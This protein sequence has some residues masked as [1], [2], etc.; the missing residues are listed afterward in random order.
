MQALLQETFTGPNG[1][2][3][4]G[5]FYVHPKAMNRVRDELVSRGFILVSIC[6][7]YFGNSAG[8]SNRLSRTIRHVERYFLP[9]RDAGYTFA[10]GQELPLIRWYHPYPRVVESLTT[11]D[12]ESVPY[13]PS[14][15]DSNLNI[16][17]R[18]D[19]IVTSVPATVVSDFD[20][21]LVGNY[22]DMYDEGT[23]FHNDLSI[24]CPD[25]TLSRLT[26]FLDNERNARLISY[27]NFLLFDHDAKVESII[28]KV[29][30]DCVPSQTMVPGHYLRDILSSISNQHRSGGIFSPVFDDPS[31]AAR[32]T[33]R[34]SKGKFSSIR[35][36][37]LFPIILHLVVR[38]LREL[39]LLFALNK[40][41]SPAHHQPNADNPYQGH[42][43]TVVVFERMKKYLES[44]DLG[45]RGFGAT[46]RLAQLWN[47]ETRA[48]LGFIMRD[49]NPYSLTK[50]RQVLISYATWSDFSLTNSSPPPLHQRPDTPRR[51]RTNRI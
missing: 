39:V 31:Q 49:L 26:D 2:K 12:R 21:S 10:P 35:P 6:Q 25:L 37:K 33:L 28:G 47:S 40:F 51:V 38:R 45:G 27:M 46:G 4:D 24:M 22:V 16:E 14:L 11:S 20:L 44:E 7:N 50:P 9:S 23:P 43:N 5:D 13:D 19:V 32:S 34:K 29:L 48:R 3:T 15:L 8:L 17:E 18:I 36:R 1:S 30:L 41:G 42:V